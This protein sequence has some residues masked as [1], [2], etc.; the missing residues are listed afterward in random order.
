MLS[1][2]RLVPALMFML[3]L[4]LAGISGRTDA[5]L[6][7]GT[8]YRISGLEGDARLEKT[9]NHFLKNQTADIKKP[10]AAAEAA[11]ASAYRA[12]LLRGDLRDAMR[13]KGYY[14][15]K[16]RFT[17]GKKLWSGTFQITPGTAYEIDQVALKPYGFEKYYPSLA[18]LKG[19]R[20]DAVNVLGTQAELKKELEKDSCAFSLELDHQVL[21]EPASH[22]ADIT[23]TVDA[24]QSADF[25]KTLFINNGKVKQSYLRKMVPWREGSCFRRDQVEDLRAS[26]FETGLF[27]RVDLKLPDAPGKDGRVPVTL[28][29]K[30][31]APR[32]VSFGLSYYT[33]EGPGVTAGWK[34]RNFFGGAETVDL[35][36]KYSTLLQ[37]LNAKFTSPFFLRRDQSLSVNGDIKREDSDAYLNRGVETGAA[38]KRLLSKRLTATS[39][40]RLAFSHIEDKTLFTT[41]NYGLLSLPQTLAYDS[42]NNALDAT[43]G[44]L[45]EIAAAPYLDVLGN[46]PVFW[47]TEGSART[48]L[49]LTKDFTLAARAKLGSIIGAARADV[50]ATERFYAGGGG[51]VRGFG[52]QEVGPQAFGKPTG[53]RSLA[54]ASVEGRYRVTDTIGAVAFLDAGTVSTSLVPDTSDLSVGAGLGLRYYTGFGPLRLDVGVPLNKRDTTS[55]PFQVYVSIGQAF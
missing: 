24:G 2:R 40:V 23:F 54:E 33:D 12:N 18:V 41:E 3:M 37:G 34:H 46:S 28:E 7:G 30:E 47:K 14:D 35:G 27:S 10:K 22:T 43:K 36:A 42:R 39:G 5:G 50:P 53:G 16:V 25:G 15:A 32:S 6:F 8:D 52:Y 11:A 20:L 45:L 49:A 26:L 21:L 31:R 55:S 48:Y 9:I 44:W 51:S 19:Q 17:P 29:L 1:P 13:A 4:L 38:V